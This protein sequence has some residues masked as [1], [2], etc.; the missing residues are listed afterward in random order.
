M[1]ATIAAAVIGVVGVVGA[2]IMQVF[3]GRDASRRMVKRAIQIVAV[4]IALIAIVIAI[5]NFSEGPSS[6]PPEESQIANAPED[7]SPDPLEGGQDAHASSTQESQAPQKRDVL[8]LSDLSPD[9]KSGAIDI[10]TEPCV[11]NIG[12][13]FSTSLGSWGRDAYVLYYVGKDDYKNLTFVWSANGNN[14]KIDS[15]CCI[16]VDDSLVYTSPVYNCEVFDREDVVIP[17]EGAKTVKLM[18]D[19]DPYGLSMSSAC[20]FDPRFTYS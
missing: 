18:V 4:V 5:S 15:F 1:N 17:I 19:D 20:I 8:V 12:D 16:Y 10:N 2:A 13:T 11:N 14:S 6:E 7:T 9:S 3:I